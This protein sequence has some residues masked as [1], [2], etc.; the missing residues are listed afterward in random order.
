M[1]FLFLKRVKIIKRWGLCPQ[2]PV[3]HTFI[4]LRARF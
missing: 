4:F 1:R 3:F 2:T